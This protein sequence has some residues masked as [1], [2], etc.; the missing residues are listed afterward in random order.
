MGL[1][2]LAILG[3]ASCAHRPPIALA[4]QASPGFAPGPFV[5]AKAEG[6]APGAAEGLVTA[7][8]A[9]LGFTE[10]SGLKVTC[11]WTVR[12]AG[13]GAFAPDGTESGAAPKAWLQQ[14]TPRKRFQRAPRSAYSLLVVFTDAAT[15]KERYRV[16]ASQ[17]D[18]EGRAATVLPLLVKAALEMAPLPPPEKKA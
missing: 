7:R 4:S 14:G 11:A 17:V 16:R 9:A 10:G 3:L 8:L 15:G 2:A 18:K 12:P 1:A 6:Q 5:L 13:V